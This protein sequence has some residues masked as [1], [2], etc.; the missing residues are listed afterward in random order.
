MLTAAYELYDELRYADQSKAEVIVI[1]LPP[2]QL[3]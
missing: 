3:K 1:E 2:N